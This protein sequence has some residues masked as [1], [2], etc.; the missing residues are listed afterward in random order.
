VVAAYSVVKPPGLGEAVR[1]CLDESFDLAVFASPSA[2]EAF[3]QWAGERSRGIP[4]VVIGPT[5]EAAAR[6]ARFDVRGV[7]APSTAEGL[8][9]AAERALGAPAPPAPSQS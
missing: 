9:A 7:A 5:T 1:R 3:A 6:A 2:V 4:V 8:V